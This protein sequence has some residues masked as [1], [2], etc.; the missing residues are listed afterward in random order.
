MNASTTKKA[1]LLINRRFMLLWSGQSVSAIGD[2]VFETTLI[3]WIVTRIARGQPWAPLA[4]SGVLLAASIPIFLVGPIAGVLVDRWDDKRLTMLLM[5]ALRALLIFLLF[6]VSLVPGVIPLP[7]TPHGLLPIAWQ[8][9]AIYGI[10]FLASACS[11]FFNPSSLALLS[12]IVDEPQIA[13]GSGMIQAAFNFAILIGPPLGAL[14]FFAA[15]VQ[16]G[17]LIECARRFLCDP[18]PARAGKPIWVPGFCTWVWFNCRLSAASTVCSAHQSNENLL[19]LSCGLGCSC[20]GVRAADELFPGSG[21]IV[22]P[23]RDECSFQC[24][25]CTTDHTVYLTEFYWPCHG[26]V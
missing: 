25:G 19:A 3:L 18:E 15:G 21:S 22:F 5:D 24:Y 26:R 11:Q 12:D 23:G 16:W 17:L 1:G 14:L 9:G 4:V 20:S 8:L 6:L 7:F 10:V 2:F 13:R